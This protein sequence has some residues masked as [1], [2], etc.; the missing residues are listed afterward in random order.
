M[1]TTGVLERVCKVGA[2]IVGGILVLVAIHMYKFH[3]SGENLHEK[4]FYS[5]V[6]KRLDSLLLKF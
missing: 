5:K 1:T 4:Y 3:A 6:H 2:R